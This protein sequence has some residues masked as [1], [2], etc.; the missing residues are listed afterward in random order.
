MESR[1]DRVKRMDEIFHPRSIAVVGA[2]SNPVASGYLYMDYLIKSG[3]KGKIY[4]INPK[5]GEILGLQAYSAIENVPG[6]VDFVICAIAAK[7]VPDML[8]QCGPKNVRA[9][10]MFTGRMAETGDEKGIEFENYIANVAREQGVRIIGPNC[11][12]IYHPKER[13]VTN[14][15]VSLEPGSV[16][17]IIQSGGMS[18]DLTRYADLRGIR[19]SKVIAMGNGV[20]LTAC[21]Y[22]EYM[23]YDDDTRVIAMYLEG[24]KDG[25]RFF[26]LLREATAVK[27]VIILKGGKVPKGQKRTA[28]HTAVMAG[29]YST[30][31]TMFRQCNVV[32]ARDFSDLV[33][34]IAGFDRLPPLKGKRAGVIGGGGGISVLAGDEVEQAGLDV[35]DLPNEVR[36][37]IGEREP[38]MKHWMGNP[39][40]FSITTGTKVD[41]H[42]L[43]VAMSKSA[44]FDILLC[45]ITEDLPLS[46]ENY[47]KWVEKEISI[48][49][50]VAQEKNLPLV[51]SLGNPLMGSRALEDKRWLCLF[52]ARQSLIENGIP[53]YATT[54]IAAGVVS[55]VADYYLRRDDIKD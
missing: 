27:P 18:W 9:V 14:Y 49:L 31:K 46:V 32:Q 38:M 8:K 22:L 19:F 5:G 53:F 43:L 55:R 1:N 24:V 33:D 13:I 35:V 2:S 52:D 51:V 48:F 44:G 10:H 7:F 40:D 4:P 28:S 15:D 6:D 39:V 34:L 26:E 21:D 20:D 50:S 25:P 12:G 54:N 41:P 16:G 17:V 37:F 45:K 47:Q 36:E 29:A 11:P 30:W 23:T 42:E 3:Y